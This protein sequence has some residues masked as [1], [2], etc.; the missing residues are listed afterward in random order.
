MWRGCGRRAGRSLPG[1]VFYPPIFLADPFHADKIS[2]KRGLK[3]RPA[4]QQ[5]F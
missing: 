1:L 4:G 5:W 2:L 3:K